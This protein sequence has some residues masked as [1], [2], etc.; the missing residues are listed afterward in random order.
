[1]VLGMDFKN[2]K[3]FWSLVI[4]NNIKTW[5]ANS[6]LNSSWWNMQILSVNKNI[7]IIFQKFQ[8]YDVKQ[9]FIVQ[10]NSEMDIEKS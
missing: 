5:N 4:Y 10:L 2:L 6:S 7:N 3:R 9:R 8:N 1:M